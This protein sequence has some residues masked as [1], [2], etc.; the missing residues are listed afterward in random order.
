VTA[1]ARSPVARRFAARIDPRLKVVHADVMHRL[2]WSRSPVARITR[3]YVRLHG[4]VVQDGP[5]KGMVYP[6]FAVG[7]GELVVAQLLGAYERELQDPIREVISHRYASIVDI[8]ASDGYYAVGFA[9]ACPEA[10]VTAFEMN[11][12]PA[13]V[14]R[15]LAAANGVADRIRLRGRCD[16]EEL[17]ALP[18]AETFVLSDCEGCERELIDPDAVPLLRS[19]SLIVELHELAAP[20]IEKLIRERFEKSHSIRIIHTEP[21]HIADYPLLLD[22]PGVSYMDREVGLSEFRPAPM[23]WA[24]LEPLM[25]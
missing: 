3:A 6:R 22:V 7:R 19:A 18:D 25:A 20:G 5:F 11:P 24:V 10:T 8:G 12:F 4:L 1:L 16:L 13:R 9:R 2:R 15:A 17:R 21:R 23:K 14:C